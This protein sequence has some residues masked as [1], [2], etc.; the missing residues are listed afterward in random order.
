MPEFGTPPYDGQVDIGAALTSITNGDAGVRTPNGIGLIQVIYYEDTGWPAPDGVATREWWEGL[1]WDHSLSIWLLEKL[2]EDGATFSPEEEAR[3]RSADGTQS[4]K[5]SYEDLLEFAA[6]FYLGSRSEY[7]APASGLPARSEGEEFSDWADRE[8][9]R[10][11]RHF[12]MEGTRVYG[13]AGIDHMAGLVHLLEAANVAGAT[14]PHVV[15]HTE[16]RD[17]ISVHLHRQ[18]REI[19][20]SAAKLETRIESSHN[21]LLSKRNARRAVRDDKR[22]PIEERLAAQTVMDDYYLRYMELLKEE[23]ASYDPDA[24]PGDLP[25]LK[26]V[27]IERL[28]AAATGHQKRLKGALTQQAIDN[29]A[30]CVDQDK[31]LGEIAMQCSLGSIEIGR[32]EDDIWKRAS[33]SW[34]VVTDPVEL[35]ETEEHKGAEAPTPAIGEDGDHYRQSVGIARAKAAFEAAKKKIEAVTAANVPVW[36]SGAVRRTGVGEEIKVSG[37]QIVLTLEQPDASI[38]GAAQ[39]TGYAAAYA[40]GSGAAVERFNVR[41]VTGQPTWHQALIRLAATERKPV[42]VTVGGRNLCGPTLVV[43]GFTP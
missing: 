37:R 5:P 23:M 27:L 7:D 12:S 9:P 15:M 33:G 8:R 18:M 19:V 25:T 17:S 26:S 6:D 40:D 10:L 14:L 32:A 30:T 31:A 34:A 35:P 2:K 36:S 22:R 4:P 3:L 38:P 13:G 11:Q 42:K 1:P 29:W 20:G 41:Q 28:E 43:V 16:R 39:I 24:L 21:V